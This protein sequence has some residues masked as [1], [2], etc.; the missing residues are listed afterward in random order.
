MVEHVRAATLAEYTVSFA[1][2]VLARLDP[3]DGENVRKRVFV[4]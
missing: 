1:V 4:D 2:T 3:N